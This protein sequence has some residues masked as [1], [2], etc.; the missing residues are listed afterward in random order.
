MGLPLQV[1]RSLI[2]P[3]AAVLPF[4]YAGQVRPVGRPLQSSSW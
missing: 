3:R 1:A 4:Y 2:A